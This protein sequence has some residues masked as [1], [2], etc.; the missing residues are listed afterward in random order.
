MEQILLES[1]AEREEICATLQFSTKNMTEISLLLIQIVGG[2]GGLGLT[3]WFPRKLKEM[4]ID[5]Y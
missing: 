1:S 3:A 5:Y 2:R 4:V